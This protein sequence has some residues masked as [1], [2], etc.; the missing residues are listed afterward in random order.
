MVLLL[1]YQTQELFKMTNQLSKLGFSIEIDPWLFI[2][3]NKLSLDD[4]AKFRRYFGFLG[5]LLQVK[6]DGYM[7]ESFVAF[8]DL[9]VMVFH[10]RE[11][12]LTPTLEEYAGR[13]N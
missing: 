6:I 3:Y 4:S 9:T 12:E 10:F 1:D 5:S 2:W 13:S 7:L 11:Q 8:W